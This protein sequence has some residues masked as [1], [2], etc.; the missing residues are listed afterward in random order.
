[1][2]LKNK[3]K[4]YLDIGRATDLKDSRERKIYRFFEMVPGFLVWL[5]LIGMFIA[6]WLWPT[7]TSFFII[8]FCT[9]WLIR[10]IHFAIHMVMAYRQ[11]KENLSVDWLNK[12]NLSS[13]N[14]QDIYHLVIFPTYKEEISV[15]RSSFDALTR[16][17]YP[18]DKLIVV[19]AIE[20]REGQKAKE[21]AD[22]IKKEFANKFFKFLITIHPSNIEGEI[23]GKGSNECWAGR[24]VKKEIIDPLKIP[25]KNI[26]VSCFD[27][28]T[29]VYPDYFGCLA[30]Y[31]LTKPNAIRSSFQPIPFYFNNIL[32]APFFSRVVSSSNVFWQM[33]QQQRPEKLTTYSSHST[34]F[35]VLV[36]IDFWQHNVVSEDAGIFWK[37]FLYYDGNYEIIPIHYPLSMDSCVSGS[38]WRTIVNQYKQ[39]RRWAWGSEGI[40]YLLFG[41]LKNKKIPT[42]KK[43][44]YA[45]LMTESFWAWGTNA[46]MIALLG[47]LPLFLGGDKFNATLLS[48]N[49]PQATQFL[50]TLALIGA[51]TLV[52]ISTLTLRF[53]PINI[54]RR[55]TLVMIVQW[56]FLPISL[57]IFGAF[58]AIEAQTRLMLG[59]Y[60]GF[61]PTEKF[62][63]T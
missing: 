54:N 9:Y 41:F 24:Q 10:T 6:S 48:Y 7:Y 28:D 17:N 61:F 53:S 14:W 22:L 59:K 58:P 37:A 57:V 15:L 56:F 26:I 36:D 63:R 29:Q 51:I 52:V 32:E 23:A 38:T 55:K 11:M 35:Q 4:Y 44:R 13:K 60:L 39:Q 34:P 19:L 27:A 12:L 40:P 18:S 33:M 31:Y 42:G 47:W 1:M 3:E 49:L 8:G 20:E 2:N 46:L 16:S 45:F 50:M 21:K 25:Y 43:L 62:R 30:Y 5:T